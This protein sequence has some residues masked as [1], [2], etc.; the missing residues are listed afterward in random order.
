MSYEKKALVLIIPPRRRSL[1]FLQGSK[2]QLSCEDTFV[3]FWFDLLG[4]YG[5]VTSL[6]FTTKKRDWDKCVS[7]M[8]LLNLKKEHRV[9]S[10]KLSSI[11]RSASKRAIRVDINPSL[12]SSYEIL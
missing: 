2:I 10:R 3:I 8:S 1:P 7:L 11:Q 6:K 12:V 5:S 4:E 9:S